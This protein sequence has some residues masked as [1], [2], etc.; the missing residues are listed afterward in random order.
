MKMSMYV[1]NSVSQNFY[2]I[3]SLTLSTRSLLPPSPI[4][5]TEGGKFKKFYLMEVLNSWTQL[6]NNLTKQLY[7]DPNITFRILVKI[8]HT[9][10][11]HTEDPE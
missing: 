10:A 1:W 11:G 3:A 6:L 4:K 7:Y 2:S 9:V 8:I 5:H